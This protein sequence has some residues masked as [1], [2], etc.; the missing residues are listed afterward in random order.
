MTSKTFDIERARALLQEVFAPWVTDLGLRL[1]SMAPDEVTMRLPYGDRLTRADDIVCGQA[2]MTA[3][4]TCC[5]FVCWAS[6]GD[7]RN[8]TTVSQTTNFL[9]P[10]IG[11]D[12]IIRGRPLK[13]G[14]SMIF[15]EVSIVGA[16]N[17]KPVA[18][19]T[20]TFAVLP[21]NLD[22]AAGG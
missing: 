15:L 22:G 8:V 5:V 13:V 12:V 21:G 9:R 7:T 10:A 4:D 20:S 11:T 1:E 14:R 6:L 16:N 3:I 2:M 17:D 18:H 19:G